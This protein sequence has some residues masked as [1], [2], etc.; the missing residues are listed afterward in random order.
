MCPRCWLPRRSWWLDHNQCH[1]LSNF[2]AVSF[3]DYSRLSAAHERLGQLRRECRPDGRG[4]GW[5]PAS[6]TLE[7]PSAATK[8]RRIAR[9]P[10]PPETT[11]RPPT[12]RAQV[13]VER[14]TSAGAERRR[15][16]GFHFEVPASPAASSACILRTCCMKR[17][18]IRSSASASSASNVNGHSEHFQ[19]RDETWVKN[20]CPA[21]I[22]PPSTIRALRSPGACLGGVSSYE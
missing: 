10:S 9:R 3:L 7:E 1:S 13:V 21:A 14:S 17:S 19:A 2:P 8:L 22:I 4:A 5:W 15:R 12:G 11:I 20:A 18:S 6:V 16:R